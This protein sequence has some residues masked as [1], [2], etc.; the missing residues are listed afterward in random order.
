MKKILALSVMGTLVLGMQGCSKTEPT[1]PA[2]AAVIAS[3][4]IASKDHQG[5]QPNAVNQEGVQAETGKQPPGTKG[6]KIIR[7]FSDVGPDATA[8][9]Y[10]VKGRVPKAI[11]REML[12]VDAF[13]ECTCTKKTEF[14]YSCTVEATLYQLTTGR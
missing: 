4:A 14:I 9:C 1:S 5:D 3:A 6:P 13:G 10:E 8:A 2:S 7:R 11:K 12:T